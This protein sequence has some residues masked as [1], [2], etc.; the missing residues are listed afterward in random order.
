LRDFFCIAIYHPCQVRA[1]WQ[2]LHDDPFEDT[3]IRIGNS[4]ASIIAE[5][6]E[7]YTKTDEHKRTPAGRAWVPFLPVSACAH[8]AFADG[9]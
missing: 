7:G 2:W 6:S 3:G 4:I 9:V 1:I 8:L 5:M